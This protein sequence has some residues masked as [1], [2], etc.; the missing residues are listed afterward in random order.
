MEIKF[1]VIILF[2]AVLFTG[3]TAQQT[4]DEARILR[5][6]DVVDML[7]S[8][9][10]EA[11]IIAKIKNSPSQFNTSTAAL[12]AL[13]QQGAT[14]VVILAMIEAKPKTQSLNTSQSPVELKTIAGKNRVYVESDDEE[15][16]L[17]LMKEAKKQKFEVVAE[18]NEADLILDMKVR[19]EA[20]SYK[21]GALRGGLERATES[22]LCNLFVYL[23]TSEGRRTA[24]AKDIKSIFDD[25]SL[26]VL[27]GRGAIPGLKYQVPALLKSFTNELKKAVKSK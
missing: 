14:D 21:P 24:F 17:L 4:L 10:G 15:V 6:D 5:N 25:S 13:K 12:K 7:K 9:L 2:V 22:R 23:R 18:A 3:A 16:R 19:T 11:L 27:F 26:A 1:L 8:G 20:I